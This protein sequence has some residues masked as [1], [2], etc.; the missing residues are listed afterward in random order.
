MSEGESPTVLVALVEEWICEREEDV[1]KDVQTI[2]GRSVRM[3]TGSAGSGGWAG[4]VIFVITFLRW[5]NVES[6]VFGGA[7]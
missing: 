3:G 6:S 5:W 4:I 7:L 1:L 2:D